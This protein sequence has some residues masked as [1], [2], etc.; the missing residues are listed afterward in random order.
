MC[1]LDNFLLLTFIVHQLN[2]S[3]I[4]YVS[5][6]ELISRFGLVRRPPRPNR[7]SKAATMKKALVKNPSMKVRHQKESGKSATKPKI[8]VQNAAVLHFKPFFTS[9]CYV[10]FWCYVLNNFLWFWC[11]YARFLCNTHFQRRIF[12]VH[13]LLSAI[14]LFI[15]KHTVPI[16]TTAIKCDSWKKNVINLEYYAFGRMCWYVSCALKAYFAWSRLKLPHSI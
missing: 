6:E 4:F 13:F 12:L 11:A 10:V 3:K 2:K 14:Q 15:R 5:G 9:F 8:I 1:E 7:K 16:H